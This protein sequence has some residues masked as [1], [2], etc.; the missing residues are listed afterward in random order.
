MVLLRALLEIRPRHDVSC[1]SVRRPRGPEAVGGWAC[2]DAVLL[3]VEHGECRIL[4]LRRSTCLCCLND[5][6]V[7]CE[8]A[9]LLRSCGDQWVSCDCLLI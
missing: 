6:N 2:T 5:Y 4:Q 1:P 7:V 8:E 3:F 9:M